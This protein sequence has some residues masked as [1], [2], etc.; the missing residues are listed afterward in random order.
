MRGV[1]LKLSEEV[2]DTLLLSLSYELFHRKRDSGLLR[3]FATHRDHRVNQSGGEREICSH[4]LDSVSGSGHIGAA[5]HRSAA[6][7][8]V[9]H[10]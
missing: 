8:R 10:Q 4:M 3:G 7:V 9:N 2:R 6:K 1:T 5:K